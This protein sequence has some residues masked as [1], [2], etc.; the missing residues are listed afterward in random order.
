M[1]RNAEHETCKSGVQTSLMFL[2][3]F[4]PE[5]PKGKLCSCLDDRYGRLR[6]IH[7]CIFKVLPWFWMQVPTVNMESEF[8]N[9]GLDI[10]GLG[11]FNY[12]F[13]AINTESPVIQVGS[14]QARVCPEPGCPKP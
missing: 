12:D 10:I 3:G 5:C 6:S 1:A 7:D 14:E 2:E 9:L 13:G 8:L 11:V 4:F